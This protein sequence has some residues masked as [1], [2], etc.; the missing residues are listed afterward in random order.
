MTASTGCRSASIASVGTRSYDYDATGNILNKSDYGDG[1][2]YG[3]GTAGPHAVTEVKNGATSLAT[4]SYDANG[5]MI[6]G[7]G[8]SI[9]WTS[10]NKAE[11][12]QKGGTTLNFYYD[13]DHNR[14]KQDTGS[15]ITYYLSSGAHYE[16][17]ISGSGTEHKHYISA[18]GRNVAIYTQRS[19]NTDKTRYLHTDHLGST[20][21]ITDENKQIVERQSFSPFGSRRNT[22]W[23][24][25]TSVLAGIETH[26]GFTGHEQLDDVGIIHMNG[27]LYDPKLGR[28]LS[29]D[30]QVQYP[31]QTQ[32]F[33]RYT[34]VNNNPLSFTDPS[35]YGF[36]S[37]L[38][39][40][41]KKVFKVLRPLI[42]IAATIWTFGWAAVMSGNWFVAGLAGGFVGGAISTGTLTGAIQ[43]AVIGGITGGLAEALSNSLVGVLG[44]AAGK[45]GF[46]TAQA[47]GGAAGARATGGKWQDGFLSGAAFAGVSVKYPVTDFKKVLANGAVGGA[48]AKL[49]GAKFADGFTYSGLSSS[50]RYLY[51]KAVTYDVDWSSG[52]GVDPRGFNDPPRQGYISVGTQGEKLEGKYFADFWKEG[53]FVSKTLNI[54]P[55][56]NAVSKLHDRIV[57][58]FEP[59]TLMRDYFAN[60]PTMLPAAALT[61]AGLVDKTPSLVT[62]LSVSKSLDKR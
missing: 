62:A 28:F 5:N 11:T 35:G 25:P 21:V 50:A 44:S 38:W 55:G 45:V 4:Y 59:G 60:A 56:I 40:G 58:K 52:K 37:K 36:F 2:T 26:H 53:G 22:D 51:N 16:K 30:I 23:S 41:I 43:G 7:D 8:R 34:Y 32:S 49:Q 57:I 24:S 13:A 47:L 9:A 54:I 33:N 19:D 12:I 27:R 17:E 31:D 42:A 14:V 29:P 10:F 39:K 3:A 6:S 20:D 48:S 18:G 46:A 61:Y 1:Y 15:K